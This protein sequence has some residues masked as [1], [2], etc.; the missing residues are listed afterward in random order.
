MDDI[1]KTA[2]R[3]AE[4]VNGLRPREQYYILFNAI[5]AVIED[6]PD[7]TMLALIAVQ[8]YELHEKALTKSGLH[9]SPDTAGNTIN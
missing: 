5:E 1:I 9:V 8:L 3:I 7:K 4:N 2:I 6:E